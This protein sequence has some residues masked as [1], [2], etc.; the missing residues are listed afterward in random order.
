[1][2]LPF[3]YLRQLKSAKILLHTWEGKSME[4]R[5]A[6]FKSKHPRRTF[7]AVLLGALG[8]ATAVLFGPKGAR[9]KT[10]KTAQPTGPILYRRTEETE[11]YYRTLYR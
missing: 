1:M 5:G 6:F 3:P 11:R 9:A 10:D 2:P 8:G 7:L 4:R